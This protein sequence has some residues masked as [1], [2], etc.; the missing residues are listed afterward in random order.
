MQIKTL[1]LKN[2]RNYQSLD[3]GFSGGHNVILGNNAQG[4]TNLLESVYLMST[5]VSARTS[6]DSDLITFGKD[7]ANVFVEISSVVGKKVVEMEIS[8][9]TKKKISLNYLPITKM[10]ELMGGVCSVY[11]SPDQLKLVKSSPDNRRKFLDIDLCQMSKAYFYTLHKYNNILKQRNALLKKAS[12]RY[13]R[14]TLPIWDATL[15]EEGAKIIFQRKKF[16]E[17]LNLYAPKI[18]KYLTQ[19]DDEILFEYVSSGNGESVE[20]IRDSLK[21]AFEN[22]IEKDL[23]LRY[24]N[25]GPQRDDVKITL[26]NIDLRSFGSQGQQRTA[27]LALMLA[28]MEIFCEVLKEYPVLL[29]DDVLGELDLGRQQKLISYTKKFQTIITCTHIPD[30]VD[31]SGF[32]ILKIKDGKII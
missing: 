17:K 7:C 18:H 23:K 26:K 21:K 14:E 1:K 24:T 11:F 28:E 9:K 10:A 2:F 27:T 12:E 8:Q 30:G 5:G 31:S 19:N 20:E 25:S 3:V 16:C 32:K 15:S 29:L 4:K 13:A 6:K 22:D